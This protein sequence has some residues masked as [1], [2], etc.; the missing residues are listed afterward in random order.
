MK[1]YKIFWKKSAYKELSF[2]PVNTYSKILEIVS[3]LI[4]E[5][6]PIKSKKLF[7]LENH[8]RIR[9][10]DYRLI[11]SISDDKLIIEIIR[12]GHR[13]DIYKNFEK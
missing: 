13:K 7:T 12:I 10:G 6:R 3:K 4:Y 1:E 2:L 8:Y 5:P 11:Y 9:I